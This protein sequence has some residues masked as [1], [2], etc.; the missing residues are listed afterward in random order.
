VSLGT[1]DTEPVSALAHVVPVEKIQ[2]STDRKDAFIR[3]VV[4]IHNFP[5]GCFHAGQ[6]V[7]DQVIAYQLCNIE[8]VIGGHS[9][10]LRHFP[11]PAFS[12]S[13]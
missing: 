2:K 4:K 11:V 8:P 13:P 12:H 9:D 1:H 5:R 6:L 7:L 3:Q 10:H